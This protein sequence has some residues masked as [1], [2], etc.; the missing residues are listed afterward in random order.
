[1]ALLR[2]TGEQSAARLREVGDALIDQTMPAQ[3]GPQSRLSALWF[4]ISHEM[5][6]RGQLASYERGFGQV[7]ALTQQMKAK[8]AG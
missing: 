5:Y 2:Q 4:A 6:H 8:L 1:V 3:K 7:P